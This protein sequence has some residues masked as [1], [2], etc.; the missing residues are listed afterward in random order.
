MGLLEGFAKYVIFTVLTPVGF[1]CLYIFG[2]SVITFFSTIHK[3]FSGHY[4]EAFFEYF[5]LSAL[6]P[7]S[8]IQVIVQALVGAVCAG[9]LWL[10]AMV[11]RGLPL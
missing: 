11:K 1:V 9:V 2:G 4:F 3:V 10:I 8:F 6:P 5:I 7:T